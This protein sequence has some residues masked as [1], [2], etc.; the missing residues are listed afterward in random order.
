M[1]G[2]HRTYQSLTSPTPT[3]VSGKCNSVCRETMKINELSILL[4]NT[5][6]AGAQ[7]ALAACGAL[8][9]KV[10]KAEAYRLYGRGNVDRW[11]KEKLFQVS[12]KHID[13]GK[14]ARVAA[15]S[16]RISYLSAAER[17]HR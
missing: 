9:D 13:R 1:V 14:L 4:K 7:K 17:K 8:P 5:A 10:T 3:F 16:N 11:L 12:E 6:T 2:N 15:A